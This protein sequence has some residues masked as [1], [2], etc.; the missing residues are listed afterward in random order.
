MKI[1]VRSGVGSGMPHVTSHVT[2]HVG[3]TL[4]QDSKN[5]VKL[6]QTLK[7]FFRPCSLSDQ[8]CRSCSLAYPL[9]I[10]K[11]VVFAVQIIPTLIRFIR[12]NFRIC[13]FP[14]VQTFGLGKFDLKN[15]KYQGVQLSGAAMVFQKLGWPGR[16]DHKF[17]FNLKSDNR[18][19]SGQIKEALKDL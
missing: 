5:E 9:A 10:K 18:I 19:K 17:F 13:I 3:S 14:I 6:L 4:H 1:T 2:Y 11:Q 12:S 8:I 7:L 16:S 15:L